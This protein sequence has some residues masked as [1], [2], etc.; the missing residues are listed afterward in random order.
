MDQHTATGETRDAGRRDPQSPVARKRAARW[1]FLIL[2]V[3]V[4]VS[5]LVVVGYLVR[6]RGQE[7]TDNAQIDADVVP[8]AARTD[9]QVVTMLVQD[10]QRVKKGDPILKMDDSDRVTKVSQAEG[11]LIVAK[12]QLDAAGNQ[13]KVAGAA[14]D[15]ALADAKR[16]EQDLGRMQQ[17]RDAGAGTQERLDDVQATSD[18][19]RAT[20][21]QAKATVAAAR[22]QSASARGRVQ[23]TE[24]ALALAKTQLAYTTVAA[25]ADGVVSNLSAH[26]GQII[27]PGQPIGEL[28]PTEIYVVA[29][30]KET[31]V[32]D[33]RPG[34]RAEI[35]V[36]AFK[37]RT[38]EGEV[39]SVSGGTGARFS[40]L[41]PDNA[42]GNFVKVVQR[43]PVRI[44]W[45][46][47]PDGLLLQ[48]GLSAEVRVFVGNRARDRAVERPSE[49]GRPEGAGR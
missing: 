34:D 26:E 21:A 7:R 20:A 11:E 13:E 33:M 5:L 35:K 17:L 14:L 49:R 39:E 15:R 2:G 16:A 32:G 25:P 8:I 4:G 42:S 9:G 37:G 46:S 30:F 44:R 41:P 28:I 27:S 23:T 18:M 6:T 47:P 1:A 12:A 48:A 3:I 36:D 19:A 22:A 40:M 45:L 38:F 29:N 31:Q 24:A 43:V 10:N